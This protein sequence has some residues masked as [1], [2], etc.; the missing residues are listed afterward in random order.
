MQVLP[1]LKRVHFM[2]NGGNAVDPVTDL[3][4]A[5]WGRNLTILIAEDHEI[6]R[7]GLHRLIVRALGSRASSIVVQYASTLSEAK[8]FVSACAEQPDLIFLDLELEDCEAKDCMAC[9]RR[10]WF[11]L[12][13]V[14]VTASEDWRQAS[15]FLNF[16]VLGVIS[17]RSSVEIITDAIRLIASGGRYFP[18]EVL[19]IGMSHV[20]SEKNEHDHADSPVVA[21][22]MGGRSLLGPV[23]PQQELM[24]RLSPR[25]QAVL[26][27]IAEGRSN[28][29][30]AKHLSLSVGTAKNYVSSILRLLGVTRRGEAIRLATKL[31]AAK[32]YL[33]Q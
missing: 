2:K 9:I 27:L 23:D 20:A 18:D 15:S 29:E 19:R 4:G 13:V 6:V 12:P 7:E 1:G 10:E 3:G 16:G 8:E 31:L 28:K 33:G 25:Q 22:S 30:I 32:Q 11:G 5:P 24:N 26:A 17:K 14:I 21:V